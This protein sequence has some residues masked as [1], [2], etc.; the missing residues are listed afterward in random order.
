MAIS[1]LMPITDPERLNI[2]VGVVRNSVGEYLIQQRLPDKPCAGQWE[3]PGGKIERGESAEEALVRELKEELGIAVRDVSLFLQH[4]H[5]YQHA[6]VLLHVFLVN[7]FLGD[8]EGRE[9]QKIE[10]KSTDGI[11]RMNALEAV[12]PILSA[13]N[14]QS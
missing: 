3:F 1:P 4:C 13:L 9:G 11:S 10:W 2:A 12:H 8:A 14:R 7:D 6:N 5:D